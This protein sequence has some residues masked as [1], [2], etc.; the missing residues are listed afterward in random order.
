MAPPADPVAPTAPWHRRHRHALGLAGAA[1]AAGMTVVWTVVVPDKAD[2]TSGL[3]S[4][5]IR[6]GHPLTWAFLCGL[7][8]AYAAGTPRSVRDP[9]AWA[10]LASYA[11]FLAALSL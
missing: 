10:A 3:Q 6:W 7:G 5:A 8:L 9:L 1:V 11:V 2:T 4:L